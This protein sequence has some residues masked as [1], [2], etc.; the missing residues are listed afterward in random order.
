M[1]RIFA[2]CGRSSWMISSGPWWRWSRGLSVAKTIPWFE[3]SR[4]PTLDMTA[5]TFGFLAMISA[6]WACFSAIA[7]NEM[8]CAPSVK[9]KT[10]PM[11]SLGRKPFGILTKSH[12]VSASTTAEKTIVARF[13]ASV[14]R[15][16]RSYKPRDR[17]RR[18]SRAL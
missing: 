3:L 17:R 6:I 16:V 12:A 1:P 18:F 2:N 9:P 14:H 8:P 13:L 7:G 4:P 11:S 10:W 15:S 5:S